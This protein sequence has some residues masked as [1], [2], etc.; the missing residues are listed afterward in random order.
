MKINE[1]ISLT[2]RALKVMFR[3]DRTY[4]LCLIFGAFTNALTPYISIFFSAKLI[5]ALFAAEPLSSL[6]LYI[7]LTVGL[8]FLF[9][10]LNQWISSVQTKAEDAVYR[11]EAWMYSEKAMSMAYESVEDHDVQLLLE[12]IKKETQTGFNWYFLH[13]F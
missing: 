11:A 13:H 10:V 7:S 5:D 3:L 9:T 8:T 2:K 12:R 4:T 6:I 1:Q